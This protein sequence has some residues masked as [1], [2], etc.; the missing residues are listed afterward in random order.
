MATHTDSL[1]A[2]LTGLI[3]Y[4]GLFPPSA[5]SM[6][7]AVAEYAKQRRSR[8]AYALA[9]FIVPISRLAEFSEAASSHLANGTVPSNVAAP[10]PWGLSVLLDVAFDEGLRTI[11]EFNESHAAGDGHTHKHAHSA[12]IDTIEIK[13]QT[14]EIIEKAI[15]KLPED[16]FPFFEL[17]VDGD[18]RSFATAL[19]GTG[20]GAK[21]R[22]GG[23]VPEMIPT[24]ERVAE[25]L[26]TM[27]QADVPVKCTAGLHHPFRSEQALTYKPDSPR[28]VMHG[29]VNVF[30]AAAAA[31]A[32][33]ADIRTVTNILKETSPEA[34]TFDDAGASWRTLKLTSEQLRNAREEFAICFG[35][36]S[37]AE[38]VADLKTLG[39]AVAV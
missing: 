21:L 18:F 17:P 23:V 31:R 12:I 19:A 28:A 33:E 13:V 5:L 39:H 4:A 35:S 1:R 20:Y 27:A 25:F 8:E 26:V 24:P 37:F 34:F 15:D 30:F 38:P 3:D 14:P 29:F 9:R 2:L 22:T 36:C 16:L 32:L 7:D 11:D 10:E 6:K